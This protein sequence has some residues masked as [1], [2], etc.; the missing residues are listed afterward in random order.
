MSCY[1]AGQALGSASAGYLAD[2][3]SRKYTIL[4]AAVLGELPALGS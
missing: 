1:N 2:K 3:F 4:M